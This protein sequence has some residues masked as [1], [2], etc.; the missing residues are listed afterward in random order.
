MELKQQGW[1]FTEIAMD[2]LDLALSQQQEAVYSNNEEGG[3]SM[4]SERVSSIASGIYAEF[5][6]MIQVYGAGVLEN[7]MP[8]VVN[9]LEQLDSVYSES[10]EQTLELEMLSEDNEQLITQYEREKQL[11]KLA[12]SVS[13]DG[14]DLDFTVY[15]VIKSI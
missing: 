9:V 6:N 3:N 7:L 12:E 1:F 11:R 15:S 13:F 4:M 2:H 8:M 10:R 5:E 14:I